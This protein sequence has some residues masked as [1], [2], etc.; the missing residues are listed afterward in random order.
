MA[1]NESP[2]H[3]GRGSHES[4]RASPDRGNFP[5]AWSRR[6]EKPKL[7]ERRDPVV[8]ADLLD[9]LTV[10]QTQDRGA[11]EVHLPPR[12]RGQRAGQEILEGRA[13]MRAAALPL[14][15]DVVAL[16]DQVRRAPEL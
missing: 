6:L 7:G 11:G 3:P 8:E 1:K 2:P 9:D 15:D 10:P 4:V 5:I 14:A 13:G 16:G 12:R